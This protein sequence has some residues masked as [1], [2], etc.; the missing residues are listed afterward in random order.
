MINDRSYQVQTTISESIFQSFIDYLIYN[1]VLE[2]NDNN[3]DELSEI[4]QEFKFERLADL[5]EMKKEFDPLSY[6]LKKLIKQDNA[7][8]N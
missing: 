4:N 2:I 8:K 3:V 7:I 1:K 6:N 5:I